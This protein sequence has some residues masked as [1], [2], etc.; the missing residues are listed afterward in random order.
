[1][2]TRRMIPQAFG[3]CILSL[4]A[5]VALAQQAKPCVPKKGASD[6]PSIEMLGTLVSA[7]GSAEAP[8]MYLA[9]LLQ[10]IQLVFNP[11]DTIAELSTGQMSMWLHA[12]GRL[13]NA[14]AVDTTLSDELVRAL[15]IAIDST[16]RLGGIGPVF[17][18]LGADSVPVRLVIHFSDQRAPF[19]VPLLR[20]S[21]PVYYEFQ[22]EKP[23]LLK[24]GNPAPDYPDGLREMK[25]QGEVLAQ[26]VVNQTG[27]A[28]MQTFRVL[29]STHEGFVASVRRVLPRMRFLPAELDGCPVR[30]LVQ[31]PFAFKMDW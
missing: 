15:G 16:S 4:T 8:P 25:V 24:P 9:T 23:A 31:L 7:G 27:Q 11:P 22:V 29:K 13:T 30:Q 21:S 1:M 5:S 20:F 18:S 6:R 2:P 12:D 28:E 14:R 10:E 19:S 3:I 26:F 17:P